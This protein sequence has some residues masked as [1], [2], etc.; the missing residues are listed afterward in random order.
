MCFKE[1]FLYK[2]LPIVVVLLINLITYSSISAQSSIDVQIQS[3]SFD[4]P[5]FDQN[6][7]AYSN[8]YLG[9]ILNPRLERNK[10][11]SLRFSI[12]S[13]AI[14]AFSDPASYPQPILLDGQP[15]IN[16]NS[17]D[18][19]SYFDLENLIFNDYSKE[20]YIQNEGFPEGNYQVCYELLD[21]SSD[22]YVAI[23]TKKCFY[24][25]V[26]LQD[27]PIFTN[28]ISN[29][30]LNN[31]DLIN[32]NW[33]PRHISSSPVVYEFEIYEVDDN[34]S[35]SEILA[36]QT[37][38]VKQN[39]NI[40]F[41]NT[42]PTNFRLLPN[43]RYFAIIKAVSDQGLIRFKNYGYSDPLYFNVIE[44]LSS[45]NR[46][47]EVP[48]LKKVRCDIPD[49]EVFINEI[50]QGCDS[51]GSFRNE[52]IELVAV[53]SP[54]DETV[55]LSGYIIDDNNF[56]GPNIGNESGHIR[57]GECFSNVPKGTIIVIYN[58]LDVHPSISTANNGSPN[59]S[60]FYQLPF[61]SSC[62]NYYPD[63]P[64]QF[65][66]ES[67]D[68]GTGTGSIGWDNFIPMRNPV[69]VLQVRDRDAEFRHG[70][71]WNKAPN[72]HANSSRMVSMNIGNA[73]NTAFVF[74]KNNDWNDV[75]NWKSVKSCTG[76]PKTP[77]LPSESPGYPNSSENET[78]I[79]NIKSG[80][81]LNNFRITCSKISIPP[82]GGKIE[83]NGGGGTYIITINN[84]PP[85]TT[86]DNPYYIPG[87]V[88]GIYSIE[89][90]DSISGCIATC[91]LEIECNV[92][93]VCDDGDDCTENDRINKFCACVGTPI[94]ELT[95]DVNE[96]LGVD[97]LCTYC[98]YLDTCSWTYYVQ[99]IKYTDPN[100]VQVTLNSASNP[101]G[102][103]FPYCN[104]GIN[105]PPSFPGC[106]GLSDMDVL[107]SDL[108]AY[109][110]ANNIIGTACIEL[111]NQC[112]LALK[113]PEDE[114]SSNRNSTCYTSLVIKDTELV[115]DSIYRQFFQSWDS[116]G[117]FNEYDCMEADSSSTI[118][119]ISTCDSPLSYLWSTGDTTALIDFDSTVSCYWVTVTC[120]MG[121]GYICEFV[122]S[123]GDG[124]DDCTIGDPC[125]DGDPCTIFD[126]Y[127]TE[128]NCVGFDA[129]D[130]DG[131]GYCDP[132]DI[133]PGFDDD[134]DLDQD[135]I[136]DGC[137]EIVACET[138]GQPCNDYNDCTINDAIN[139]NCVCKGEQIIDVTVLD[140]IWY[141]TLCSYCIPIL[142]GSY[143][144]DDTILVY[145]HS[146]LITTVDGNTVTLDANI[147]YTGFDFP[148]C[149][150]LSSACAG[151]SST[152]QDL[153]NHINNWID[154][155]NHSGHI[156]GNKGCGGA[157]LFISNANFQINEMVGVTENGDTIIMTPI[158]EVCEPIESG[159]HLYVESDCDSILTY[160][161][162]TGET[163]SH[164]LID[165][166]AGCYQVSITC[167]TDTLNYCELV[168]TWGINCDSCIVGTSCNDLDT[169]TV[170]DVIDI[171]CNCVGI[172]TPD[173]D[174]DEYCDEIDV[175][176]GFDDAVDTDGDGVPDGCDL[177]HG[178]PDS[179]LPEYIVELLTDGDPSN[180]P[181][182][183]PWGCGEYPCNDELTIVATEIGSSTCN[184]CLD[185]TALVD[186]NEVP[187]HIKSVTYYDTNG[188][189]QVIDYTYETVISDDDFSN[190]FGGFWQDISTWTNSNW[191]ENTPH[192]H[193]PTGCI[194]L[195]DDTSTSQLRSKAVNLCEAFKVKID[196]NFKTVNFNKPSHYFLVQILK[197]EGYV[198]IKRY[199]YGVDFINDIRYFETLEVD[200]HFR[201]NSRIRILSRPDLQDERLYLDDI[202]VTA[203]ESNVYSCNNTA[204][205]DFI[206][207][208]MYYFAQDIDYING[209]N[210]GNVSYTDGY[211]ALCDTT[212]NFVSIEDS[213][214]DFDKVDFMAG[215]SDG[216]ISFY[217]PDCGDLGP[218]EKLMQYVVD[219]GCDDPE[220]LWSNGKTTD[221][222]L[223]PAI[224]GYIVTVMCPDS[225]VYTDTII[226]DCW[227]GSG[228]CQP[229]ACYEN[230][231]YYDENCN[232][233]GATLLDPIENYD[234]D[235][236][237]ICD[238]EDECPCDGENIDTDGDGVCD[239]MECPDLP[240][241]ALKFNYET[242]Y[243]EYCDFLIPIYEA[244]GEYLNYLTL[245]G[246]GIVG[247]DPMDFPY[248]YEFIDL[249]CENIDDIFNSN[250]TVLPSLKKFKSHFIYFLSQYG[251]KDFVFKD[252]LINNNI[253][254]LL[255]RVET[256][257]INLLF[258]THS[259][260]GEKINCQ[261]LPD[262][263]NMWVK[264]PINGPSPF[265][266]DPV[267]FEWS[268][269]LSSD[270][271]MI[272]S[273]PVG[274]YCVTITCANECVYEL[275][276]PGSCIVG[277]TCT[278]MD[279]CHIKTGFYDDYCN[280]IITDHGPDADGDGVTDKCD[281]CPGHDDKKDK[282]F[283]GIPDGCDDCSVEGGKEVCDFCSS[284][285][286]H[287]NAK[288]IP[289]VQ[290]DIEYNGVQVAQSLNNLISNYCIDIW[291]PDD[292]C[293]GGSQHDQLITT[294]NNWMSANG[295]L[296]SAE[297][298]NPTT[299]THVCCPG[300]L[301]D[302]RNN[303]GSRATICNLIRF[304]ET[305]LD[306]KGIS[307][308]YAFLSITRDFYRHNCQGGAG[309]PEKCDDGDPCTINDH[310][311]DDCNCV[312]TFTDWDN[313]WV[314]DL[315]DACPGYPDYMD[316]D[317]DG[318]P[319]G[320]DDI[321]IAC[322]EGV[323][324]PLCEYIEN[325]LGCVA[326]P[327][328]V[329]QYDLR[330][331]Q[332][333]LAIFFAEVG[334]DPS[335]FYAP[336]LLANLQS[337]QDSD[338]DDVID[339]LDPCP[340]TYNSSLKNFGKI[341][342]SQ[343]ANCCNQPGDCGPG[344]SVSNVISN[345]MQAQLMANWM[346]GVAQDMYL[347]GND[348]IMPYCAGDLNMNM[349]VD[350]TGA[351]FTDEGCNLEFYVDCDC[352][353]GYNVLND[354][355]QDSICDAIDTIFGD[356]CLVECPD[357]ECHIIVIADCEC[358]YIPIV[359]DTIIG[360]MGQDTVVAL[361][362]DGDGVCDFLDECP[363]IDDTLDS[364]GD[365]IPDC[366]DACPNGG[367]M[368]IL[369]PDIPP[370][371]GP[372]DPCDDGDPC[373][374]ADSISWNC[375]CEGIALDFD[376]DSITD[377]GDCKVYYD[378][379]NT[380][381]G[382]FVEVDFTGNFIECDYCYS[383][384]LDTNDVV[385]PD[386]P[387]D[388]CP[389]LPDTLD[390]NSNGA[391]DCI[392]PPF[393]EI[394]CP[395]IFQV[396][397]EPEPGIML[398]FGSDDFELEDLPNP[399]GLIMTGEGGPQNY[400]VIENYLTLTFTREVD[401]SFEAFY[402]LP[403]TDSLVTIN[404]AAVS[405]GSHQNCVVVSDE[406]LS[407]VTCPTGLSLGNSGNLLMSVTIPSGMNADLLEFYGTY[408]FDLNS[409]A[410]GIDPING[411]SEVDGS[412]ITHTGGDSYLINM[413]MIV[414]NIAAF[415]TYSGS[416]TLSNG[417]VC[418]YENGELEECG[419][420]SLVIG[421]PCN[422][423]DTCTHHDRIFLIDVPDPGVDSCACIGDPK[424]DR[425]GDG[426]CDEIDPCP[427][428]PN[429]GPDNDGDGYPDC[430]CPEIMILTDSLANGNDYT[431]GL[432]PSSIE[433]ISNFTFSISGGPEGSIENT[434]STEMPL[435][436]ENLPKGYTYQVTITA[437]GES[438]CISET[439]VTI[440]VPF[441][442]DPMFCGVSLND[443]NIDN[444]SLIYEL[445]PDA[446]F[447]A[448]DFEVV[449]R[450]AVGGNGRFK[451]TGYIEIP[452]FNL[453]RVNVKYDDIIVSDLDGVNTLVS[454]YVEITGIGQNILGDDI[455][456]V[457]DDIIT[458]L[459]TLDDLLE[460]IIDIVENVEELVET[461][462]DLVDPSLVEC[463][464]TATADLEALAANP[465]ATQAQLNAAKAVLQN[466][467]DDFNAAVA[468]LMADIYIVLMGDTGLGVD[469]LV[470]EFTN[471]D[472]SN[473]QSLFTASKALFENYINTDSIMF[474]NE[475]GN[476]N[477]ILDYTE[478]G[479]I[480]IIEDPTD[481]IGLDVDYYDKA[482][483]F[484]QQEMDYNICVAMKSIAT[485]VQNLEQA[486]DFLKLLL[487]AGEDLAPIIAESC[488][489]PAN[490]NTDQTINYQNVINDTKPTFREFLI[491]VLVH[492]GYGN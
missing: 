441:D 22:S 456:D 341:S 46:D 120:D 432:D 321:E 312:G 114:N 258:Q 346:F 1:Y 147:N 339:Y 90:I 100:G 324:K 431:I 225:C 488:Q 489:D 363:D 106:A 332:D 8:I 443:F 255:K 375:N 411:S 298:F 378:D 138:V 223:V 326:N 264:Q 12:K 193:S 156:I 292:S 116:P 237:G 461:M 389:S 435:V 220:I 282:D 154:Y 134:I 39:T 140:S 368:G 445:L 60:G 202:K 319:D 270:T 422:D 274:S 382:D 259:I 52:Y 151:Y 109:F 135:G 81:I 105:P 397:H 358:V 475:L 128:C 251:Y 413:G 362:S 338:G 381:P 434:S 28:P 396:I 430:P 421:A 448:Y 161:W 377:C 247:L 47:P 153:P 303:S 210:I 209:A 452:Y 150:G 470:A 112:L 230:D 429:T 425:D 410:A 27:P 379:P 478:G 98:T 276:S 77:S 340:C 290:F 373:T 160:T 143:G 352:D 35:L 123:F 297:W 180:D 129:P 91:E 115:F 64:N 356:P 222:I 302:D 347:V 97:T 15:V 463:I 171:N 66:T 231:G 187:T 280:C 288:Y 453:V 286:L 459:E 38:L 417:V 438:G 65:T 316:A 169:C 11:L 384:G 164:I 4:L 404:Y 80:N 415:N 472:E 127:N 51:K 262:G 192:A 394:G 93:V 67:Y 32:F 44:Y 57:L 219:V 205:T 426:L 146:V 188:D 200:G 386:M 176:F 224:G 6:K 149:Q 444:A 139:A 121:E 241:F 13:K 481:T 76:F 395:D 48:S 133:C 63:C 253:H 318:I 243:T 104:G 419:D 240:S 449:V 229:S 364:D 490:I 204:A 457:L 450:K 334:W 235:G 43:Q 178:Q 343:L 365:G 73:I 293:P 371:T 211:S 103:H 124:C 37:P 405:Y 328:N 354:Y 170:N 263:Q 61:N 111:S 68:C 215:D 486:K 216:F 31:F 476:G 86:T 423:G 469:G 374:F 88:P 392:D 53:G 175:C 402:A 117:D 385:G 196:F 466:C 145:T 412:S 310:L 198:T 197:K 142:P 163:S 414:S 320:C 473:L 94:E 269:G 41:Y 398:S 420:P 234:A 78:L 464:E 59:G 306:V 226:G 182:L 482:N 232:C 246:L 295:Y 62:I 484:Y 185:F 186:S 301:T 249:E 437:H 126:H 439:S 79:N 144:L 236:D 309:E 357:K 304:V 221:T 458:G 322:E 168:G 83:I 181:D 125:D 383:V 45:N 355:D 451:G 207:D 390:Y 155:Y 474:Y 69:D 257:S 277:D 287:N 454:G 252:T 300:S 17:S 3:T 87:L 36:Y 218:G 118:E 85:V 460:N 56:M 350:S 92:G 317:G 492:K 130:S 99:F 177:C 376:G 30:K 183:T 261:Y 455:L 442:T 323:F 159:W 479:N 132:I 367:F 248:C 360:S 388:I 89:V 337:M 158:E 359:K 190:G 307:G 291:L 330:E 380:P 467:I 424:P 296:G 308:H 391:P 285:P 361:D 407:S 387:C 294:I 137:D 480:N 275:C 75:N 491:G 418:P 254:F 233:V 199:D 239:C 179:N 465:N 279:T 250:Y 351:I 428:E 345:G 447:N 433:G 20:L 157:G 195:K 446:K 477:G 113:G 167:G 208:F 283:D 245:D 267:S 14:E 172:Q 244:D 162:N 462:G 148:Y 108:N 335:N 84:Q 427:E 173:S 311:D 194:E 313:D 487:E 206:D 70:I 191:L 284:L 82:A 409:T 406:D 55:D 327:G 33:L 353:C 189:Q 228:P 212:G 344:G 34:M 271:I 256:S 131:D 440:D 49:G 273:N 96:G 242:K 214:I 278:I 21:I 110:Q 408:S 265:V 18:L 403:S 71:R 9:Q 369:N 314:C 329:I 74:Y 50:S 227:V 165:T 101:Q 119:V 325:R 141:D 336:E 471:C 366:L 436:V 315:Y 16:L 401:G 174:G 289:Y 416:I 342:A 40:T 42:F 400:T 305:D 485:Q 24:Q 72:E 268:N 102:F 348:T 166:L 26:R 2:P 349:V 107:V 152:I 7:I 23:S 19:A 299:G 29:A 281:V 399:I 238:P 95:F 203:Y 393:K 372:G 184:Y 54:G 333:E 213:N 331:V 5:Y 260:D 468:D 483:L 217:S 136:P 58:N 201:T 122:D 266:C 25:S 272:P 370:P 10:R